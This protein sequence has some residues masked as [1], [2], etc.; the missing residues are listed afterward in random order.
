MRLRRDEAI[1]L[2]EVVDRILAEGEGETV[3]RPVEKIL[4]ARDGYERYIDS[5]LKPSERLER[6]LIPGVEE[7]WDSLTEDLQIEPLISYE[8]MGVGPGGGWL[9]T[10]SA[11]DLGDGRRIYTEMQSGDV[12]EPGIFLIAVTDQSGPETDALVTDAFDASEEGRTWFQVWA[13]EWGLDEDDD[14]DARG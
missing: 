1:S 3:R 10:I 13:E 12:P 4:L 7:E 6:K 11:Y 8:G 2:K 9:V 5:Q 14:G